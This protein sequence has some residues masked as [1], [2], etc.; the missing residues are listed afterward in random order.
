MAV[1][2]SLTNVPDGF[3]VSCVVEGVAAQQ[4]QFYQISRDVASWD[5]SYLNHKD[6]HDHLFIIIIVINHQNVVE[7]ICAAV[8]TLSRTDV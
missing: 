7:N 3:K 4:K 5:A 6:H 1:E 2:S 8:I